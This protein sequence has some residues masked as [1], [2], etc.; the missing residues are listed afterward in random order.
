MNF[1][2]RRLMYLLF[3]WELIILLFFAIGLKYLPLQANYLGGSVHFKEFPLMWAHGNYD[4]E[5]YLE[6]AQFGYG[7][8]R[9]FYFPLYP[10]LIRFVSKYLLFTR[11]PLPWA[12]IIISTASFFIGFRILYK[13]LRLDYSAKFSL[14]TILL[15]LIFPA[16]FFFTSIYTEALFLAL[17]VSSFYCARKNNWIASGILGLFASMTRIIGVVL[18]LS[19]LY[20]WILAYKKGNTSIKELI[21]ILCIPFGLLFYMIFLQRFT[22]DPLAFFHNLATYGGQRSDH[23]VILPQVFYR[24]IFKILPNVNSY[25]PIVLTSYFEFLSG[26]VFFI[27]SIYSFFKIRKSYALFGFFGYLIP[28][29]SGSFSSLPR[30]VAILFPLFITLSL[31]LNSKNNKLLIPTFC[32]F[33]VF[34]AV[35]SMMF[36]VGYWVS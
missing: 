5:H 9:Y 14:Q 10:V 2:M 15:I 19:I 18:F 20:E 16:S 36:V 4:G 3:A 25:I 11:F 32:L 29:L 31:L 26:V 6:I 8:F 28:T 13:L 12:G 23:L 33:A 34:L 24:Y 22:G 7:P 1:E 21:P 27:L 30:Y 17:C 35:F